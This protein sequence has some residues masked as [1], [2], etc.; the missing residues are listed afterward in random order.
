MVGVGGR[1]LFLEK[2]KEGLHGGGEVTPNIRG[3][4]KRVILKRA[5]FI[6]SRT[7]REGQKLTSMWG[8]GIKLEGRIRIKE[9]RMKK[10]GSNR[11]SVIL[12][13]GEPRPGRKKKKGEVLIIRKRRR[14][15]KL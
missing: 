10:K 2:E 13:K 15:K 12:N 4:E 7:M 9:P 1:I 5:S 14:G 6:L 11:E 3:E 8:G